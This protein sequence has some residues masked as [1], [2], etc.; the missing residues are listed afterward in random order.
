M[1]VLSRFQN[2]LVPRANA[3]MRLL[4]ESHTLFKR[5]II[6]EL[7]SLLLKVASFSLYFSKYFITRKLKSFLLH[8]W[9][10][11]GREDFQLFLFIFL[12][13]RL[14]LPSPKVEFFQ[15]IL[16]PLWHWSRQGGQ[17]DK[18]FIYTSLMGLTTFQCVFSV[19]CRRVL[20]SLQNW[21]FLKG[22][23]VSCLFFNK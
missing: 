19:I 21:K 15:K 1:I 13:Q 5:V 6:L 22:R 10:V 2:R 7:C 3:A 12:F 8:G 17:G 4:W 16:K 20:S 18:H 9:K 11:A 23:K 14:L